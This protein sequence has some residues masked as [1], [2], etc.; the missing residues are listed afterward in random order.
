MQNKIRLDEA[1]RKALRKRIRKADKNRSKERLYGGKEEAKEARKIA[2][3]FSGQGNPVA[4]AG[5]AKNM[6]SAPTRVQASDIPI[7]G[8]AFVL[9]GL[10]DLLDLSMIGSLPVIG[11]VITFCVSMAI[12]F[13]L[14]FDGGVSVAG[15]R[16]R[17]ARR[18]TRK[19]LILIAGTMVEG[20]LFGLNF[21][22]FEMITV[23]IIYWMSL[24]DRK[25]VS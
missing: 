21:L 2:R 3:N 19:F 6:V 10:K 7:Y 1:R 18:L 8:L 23:G 4:V 24:A 5:K 16:R 12:G 22:P 14:L 11:T 20:F 9:A 15:K 13:V 17:V 25:K